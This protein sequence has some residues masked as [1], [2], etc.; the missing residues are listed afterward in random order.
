MPFPVGCPRELWDFVSHCPLSSG[1]LQ[2]GCVASAPCGVPK[3]QWTWSRE[4]GLKS[5]LLL[6]VILGSCFTPQTWLSLSRAAPVKLN[7]KNKPELVETNPNKTSLHCCKDQSVYV[8]VS[9]KSGRRAAER[10]QEVRGLSAMWL[11]LH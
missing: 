11:Q 2:P 1:C 4:P 9:I 6:P 3:G 7:D 10:L 8:E 5:Q